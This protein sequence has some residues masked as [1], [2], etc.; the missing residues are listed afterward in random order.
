MSITAQDVKKLRDMTGLGLADCKKALVASNGDFQAAADYV[1]KEFG[2]K[3]DTRS[4]REA[5]EGKVA[6]AISECGC[7]AAVVAVKAET[8]FTANNEQFEGFTAPSAPHKRAARRHTRK[9]TASRRPTGILVIPLTS[10]RSSASIPW[11]SA[12]ERASGALKTRTLE[13]SG[14]GSSIVRCANGAL[15]ELGNQIFR[16]AGTAKIG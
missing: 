7:K 1:R 9:R 13:T 3:M 10:G 15:Q 2:K 4:D 11:R 8:D 16:R 6:V 14:P 12:M 5:S